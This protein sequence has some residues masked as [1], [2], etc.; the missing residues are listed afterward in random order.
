MLIL[1]IFKIFKNEVVKV[2]L[3]PKYLDF[4]RAAQ[5]ETLPAD[6]MLLDSGMSWGRGPSLV[7]GVPSRGR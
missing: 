1:Y 2:V 3:L 6:A 5:N 7:H 4:V